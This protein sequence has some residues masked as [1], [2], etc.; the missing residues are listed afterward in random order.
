MDARIAPHPL[1]AALD[2]TD[3]AR[4]SAY[5]ALFRAELDQ[6]PI[7]DMRLALNQDQPLGTSRFYAKIQRLTGERR[8][9]RPRGRPMLER[10][11]TVAV[12]SGRG[13][14]V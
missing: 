13:R 6:A 7:D 14:L 10:D 3:K 4:Q 11:E 8:E 5:R 2:S 9:A 12:P 1:Y